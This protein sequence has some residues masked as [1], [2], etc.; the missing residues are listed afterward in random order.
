M[1]SLE[2]TLLISNLFTLL[3]LY[4]LI[5][6]NRKLEKENGDLWVDTL[7][8]SE[9]TLKQIDKLQVALDNCKKKQSAKPKAPKD[10]KTTTTK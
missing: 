4:I 9:D 1:T 8:F 2:C 6:D 3:P 5:K 7:K 10:E